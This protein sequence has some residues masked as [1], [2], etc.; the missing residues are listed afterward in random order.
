M[1]PSTRS[2]LRPHRQPFGHRLAATRLREPDNSEVD[3]ELGKRFRYDTSRVLCPHDPFCPPPAQVAV[4]LLPPSSFSHIFQLEALM[5]SIA[6]FHSVLGVRAGIEDAAARLREA[7][8]IVTLV[9][10][11]DGKSFD[12]YESA[13]AYAASIGFPEL[14]R[15][16]LESVAML[17]DGFAVVGFSNGGGMATHIAVNRR[18]S[19]AVLCSG[20]LPLKQIGADRWPANVPAQLHYTA[21]DPFKVAGS[22]ESVMRSVNDAGATAEYFQYPGSGHLFTDPELVSE[23]DPTAMEQLWNHVT[24]FLQR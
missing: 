17:P 1:E 20:A 3:D 16:A 21:D 12:D 7:G 22:V 8:H 10:Q 5:K 6:L 14:M 19:R 24:R 2:A 9:D 13:G 18:I 15:R 11:Y 23:F 4:S